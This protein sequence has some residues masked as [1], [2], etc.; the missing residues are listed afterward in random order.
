VGGRPRPLTS[1]GEAHR[2]DRASLYRFGQPAAS[3]SHIIRC[4]ETIPLDAFITANRD[5]IIGRCRARSA[6]RTNPR[7]PPP[8][9]EHGVPVFLLQMVAAL[10]P[11]PHEHPEMLDTALLHGDELLGHGFTISQVV[12]DY[13]DVCQAIT[14]L[15][16]E[17]DATISA[18]HFRILNWCLDEATASAVTEY[19]RQQLLSGIDEATARGTERLGFL[20]RALRTSIHTALI[21]F[22][23]V[24]AGKVGFTGS[25]GIVLHRS[26][27]ALDALISRSM[28]EVRHAQ[29]IRHREPILMS[30]LIHELVPSTT[31]AAAA[32]GLTLSIMPVA[33]G[34]AVEADRHVLGAAVSDLL[35]NAFKFTPPG[36]AVTLRVKGGDERVLIEIRNDHGGLP[37]G[38]SIEP[39]RPFGK[40]RG[41]HEDDGGLGLAFSRWGVEAHGGWIDARNL[42][43]TG[44]VFTVDLPRLPAPDNRSLLR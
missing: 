15:A 42:P 13:G 43:K 7:T 30:G 17:R 28:A 10:A 12:H 31:L 20:A 18:D 39:F 11:G 1:S 6:A 19:G 29:G 5:E 9:L 23:A 21:A 35:Q 25:T 37:D 3:P 32:R 41:D 14:E 34:I 36:T 22:Q 16:V 38:E 33:D 44:F 24:K 2:Q 26:L 4:L 40:A 27:M 8:H